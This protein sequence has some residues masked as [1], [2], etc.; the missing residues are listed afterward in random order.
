[1]NQVISHPN[2]FKRMY[3]CFIIE[4]AVAQ[5]VGFWKAGGFALA[6]HPS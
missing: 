3:G 4:D 1:M 5:H 6:N 2:W